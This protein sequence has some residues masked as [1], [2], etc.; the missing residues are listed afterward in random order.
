M[1][2]LC[3]V[4]I[5]LVLLLFMP[6]VKQMAPEGNDCTCSKIKASG[7]LMYKPHNDIPNDPI[8][9]PTKDGLYRVSVYAMNIA[10]APHFGSGGLVY[11]SW[12]DDVR[13]EQSWMMTGSPS[14]LGKFAS[15][16]PDGSTLAIQC[17]AGTPISISV[18][19][20]QTVVSVYYSVE[21]LD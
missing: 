14:V 12:H 4:A 5:L 13:V 10:P 1:V 2:K 8:F 11:L 6:E 9:T 18:T 19:G 17:K 16:A 20:T 15:N 7:K 21:E 3:G